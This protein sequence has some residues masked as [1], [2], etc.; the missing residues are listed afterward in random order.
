MHS[1]LSCMKGDI[2]YLEN[3]F[4]IQMVLLCVDMF[5]RREYRIDCA[6]PEK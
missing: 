5:N 2:V 3:L 1:V 6:L 4:R